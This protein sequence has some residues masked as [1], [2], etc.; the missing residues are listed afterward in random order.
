[1][2]GPGNRPIHADMNRRSDCG[3]RTNTDSDGQRADA[4]LQAVSALA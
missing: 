3:Q 4:R 2:A 1:M